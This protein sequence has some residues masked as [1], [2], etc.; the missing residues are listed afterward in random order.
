MIEERRRQPGDDLLSLLIHH[1][2][3]GDRVSDAELLALV[4]ALIAAG[5]D[6]TVHTLRFMLLDLLQHRDQLALVQRDPSLARAA[7][8]ESL[9]YNHFSRLGLPM[10]ALEDVELHGVTIARGEMVFPMAGAASATR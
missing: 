5:S 10:Y 8:E 4:G 1:E 3:A 2:E 6:T 7:M 9:R